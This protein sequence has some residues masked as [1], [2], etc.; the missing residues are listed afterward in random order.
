MQKYS[1]QL[2]RNV[3]KDSSGEA[4]SLEAL[5]NNPGNDEQPATVKLPTA[6]N[7]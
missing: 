3:L 2:L 5:W 4:A 1:L 7:I 6:A